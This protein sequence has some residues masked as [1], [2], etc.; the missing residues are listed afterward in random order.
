MS[1]DTSKPRVAVSNDGDV[2]IIQGP[3]IPVLFIPRA[4]VAALLTSPAAAVA[5]I[6]TDIGAA[7]IETVLAAN[8]TFEAS[9]II[10]TS[11]AIESVTLKFLLPN[12][13]LVAYTTDED[14]ASDRERTKALGLA[15][16][17]TNTSVDWDRKHA[18]LLG[19]LIAKVPTMPPQITGFHQLAHQ[20]LSQL[21]R[22]A[23][24]SRNGQEGGKK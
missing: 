1:T 24:S 13:L 6:V 10:A 21:V 18:R 15:F 14:L 11:G 3:G 9:T 16:V 12:G 22:E 8:A 20:Y 23:L 7:A 19:S 17:V 4:H 5:L 2:L